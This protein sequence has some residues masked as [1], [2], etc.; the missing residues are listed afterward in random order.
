MQGLARAMTGEPCP[1]Q[2]WPPVPELLSGVGASFP[3]GGGH[4]HPPSLWLHSCSAFLCRTQSCSAAVE[5]AC[6]GHFPGWV[7]HNSCHFHGINHKLGFFPLL[8]LTT[9]YWGLSKKIPVQGVEKQGMGPRQ[10]CREWSW[11]RKKALP[12]VDT[13]CQSNPRTSLLTLKLQEESKKPLAALS[14]NVFHSKAWEK[15]EGGNMTI[16]QM[17]SKQVQFKLDLRGLFRFLTV[18]FR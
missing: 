6:A 9:A 3:L 17:E 14:Q 12:Q 18:K 15:I 13:C 11:R 8:V 10:L 7:P 1:G 5:G 2:A 4:S 16:K